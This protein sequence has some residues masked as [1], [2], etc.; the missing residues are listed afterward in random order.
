TVDELAQFENKLHTIFTDSVAKEVYRMKKKKL[1]EKRVKV[2]TS[3]DSLLP[4][5]GTAKSI[6]QIPISILSFL[7][8]NRKFPLTEKRTR[9]NVQTLQ[10]LINKSALDEKTALVNFLTEISKKYSSKLI[11]M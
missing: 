3:A 9:Q 1:R 4:F 10:K 5:F 8:F 2:L 11:G 7:G 6:I